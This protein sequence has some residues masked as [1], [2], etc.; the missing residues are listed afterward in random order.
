MAMHRAGKGRGGVT[1]DWPVCV[2]FGSF[3]S[4]LP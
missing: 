3:A 1:P 2:V 4:R